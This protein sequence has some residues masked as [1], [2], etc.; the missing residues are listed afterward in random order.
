MAEINSNYRQNNSKL[1]DKTCFSID[2][3]KS[4]QEVTLKTRIC[5]KVN[6]EVE[7]LS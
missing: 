4:L 6:P 1:I 7:L 3:T 5:L 2:K